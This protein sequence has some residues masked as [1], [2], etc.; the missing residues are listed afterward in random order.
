MKRTVMLCLTEQYH[1][2]AR[3]ITGKLGEEVV[4]FCGN[5]SDIHSIVFVDNENI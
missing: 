3:H 5:N 2:A 1:D 4:L